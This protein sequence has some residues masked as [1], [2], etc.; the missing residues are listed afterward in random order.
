MIFDKLGWDENGWT[1][2]SCTCGIYEKK[3]FQIV[4]WKI[5]ARN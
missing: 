4:H 3:K 2:F 5:L 1:P